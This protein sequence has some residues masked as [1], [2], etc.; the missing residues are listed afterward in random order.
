MD[1]LLAAS[2]KALGYS[3]PLLYASVVVG[4]FWW[5]DRKA[6]ARARRTITEWFARPSYNKVDVSAVIVEIFDLLY[7]R[8]LWGWRAILRSALI[9]SILTIVVANQLYPTW[10]IVSR[11]PELW[12]YAARQLGQNIASDYVSLFFIRQWLVMAGRR[13]LFA[14][15]TAPLIG[16]FIVA[17]CY[18]LI[19]VVT[20]SISMGEFH[21]RYFLEDAAMWNR[22]IHHDGVRRS[23][24]VPAFTVHLWLPLFAL[25]VLIAQLLN[26]VRLAGRFSQ[27]FFAQGEYHP[28]RSIGYI[29]GALT[30]VLMAVVMFLQ[31][32]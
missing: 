8:P 5:L 19:D 11:V 7:T 2:L 18:A 20:F 15:F 29:A 25:G 30:F 1:Q 26:S 9:S 17:G 22:L 23:L 28:L 6:A 14:L 16:A 10:G 12:Y 21:W 4:L 3:Q 32:S 13:P 31:L 27:W 24:L